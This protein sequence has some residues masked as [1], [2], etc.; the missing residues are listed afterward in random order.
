MK[1][2]SNW[3][4]FPTDSQVLKVSQQPP[5][6][7]LSNNLIYS[8]TYIFPDNNVTQALLTLCQAGELQDAV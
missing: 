1:G 7:W 6:T 3:S 4:I 2:T 5:Q 8:L